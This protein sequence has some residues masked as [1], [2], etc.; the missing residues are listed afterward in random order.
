[1][2]TT[3]I[4]NVAALHE[5]Y[6][7]ASPRS[8]E[9]FE[10]GR[11]VMCGAAKGAYFYEPYPLTMQRGEGCFLYDIDGQRFVDFA[12]HHTAQVLGHRH[13]A[14]DEAVRAQLDRGIVLGAPLGIEAEL[15]LEMCRRVA[16]LDRIRFCNSGTEATL[17]AVRLARGFSG[18]PKIAKFEGGYHGSHD[19]VEVSVS[20]SLDKAGPETEPNSVP[21]AGGIS[22]NAAKEVVVLPYNDEASVEWLVTR[23]RHELACVIFDPKAG[24]LPQRKEFVQSLREITRKNDVL[25]ILDEIVSFRVGVGGFQECYGITPD[26]TT[27]GKLIGGGFPVGAFGGRADVMDLFDNTRGSTGFFQSGTF[28]AHPVSMAAGLATLK[29][30]TPDTFAHLNDLGDRLRTGLNELFDRNRIASRAVGIGSLFSIHFTDEDV[31][32]YRSLARTD[33]TMTHPLFLGLLEQGQFLSHGLSM[34]ALSLPMQTGHIDGLIDA[35]GHVLA[36]FQP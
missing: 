35:V 4:D 3:F 6:R 11:A 21:T 16:S 9:C 25:L 14:V 20:P 30:L 10:Q 8:R 13:P 26:L 2:K 23:H 19:V 1:M 17:H 24:I 18:R 32:N 34:N 22:P 7:A 15:S 33:K 12:N 31:V 27:F 36:E 5:R 28:S 29:Q